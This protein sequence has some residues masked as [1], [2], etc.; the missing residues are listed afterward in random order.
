MKKKKESFSKRMSKSS[1]PVYEEKVSTTEK[2]SVV[3]YGRLMK[4]M[5]QIKTLEEEVIKLQIRRIL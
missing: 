4:I 5:E 2:S 1:A 3:D